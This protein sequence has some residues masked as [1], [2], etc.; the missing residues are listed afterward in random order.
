MAN[1]NITI[2]GTGSTPKTISAAHLTRL[3]NAA[4]ARLQQQGIPNP[5]NQQMIDYLQAR[6]VADWTNFVREVETEQAAASVAGIA[7]TG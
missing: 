3:Q 6:A 2:G 1:L 4:A 7:I 5:T